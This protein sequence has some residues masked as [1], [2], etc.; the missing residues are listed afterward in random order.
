MLVVVS[1][2]LLILVAGL[3]AVWAYDFFEGE[4]LVHDVLD[5]LALRRRSLAELD[6]VWAANPRRS[7][8]VVSLTTIPSRL[9]SLHWTLASLMRQTV[10]PARIVLN[11]PRFSRREQCAYDV[12]EAL[13]RLAAVEIR[14]VDDLGPA[15]KIVPTLLA[16][17]PDRMIVALDDDRIYP[18]DLIE[19]LER[20]ARADPEAAVTLGGW[21]VPAD[22][23]D[24]P[25]TIASNF[26]M[27]PPAPVRAPR[28]RARKQ[29]DVLLGFCAYLVRPRFFDLAALADWSGAPPEAFYVD[30][31]W[32]SAHCR[33]D[34]W[35][36]P[37]RLSNYQP[38]LLRGFYRA[39][40]LGL[41]NRGAGGHEKR[42]NTIVLR[43]FRQAWRVGGDHLPRA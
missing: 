28:L 12:P 13:R 9:G 14:E 20:A 31:V 43:H 36:V 8:V 40:S 25:T 4:N 3:A 5:E 32:I 23:V 38:K 19:T 34:K 22:Y 7:E 2:S 33:A 17:P 18:A 15:T 16:E 41:I 10:A 21:I 37:S 24:R 35:V 39:T 26:F 6:G 27:R 42:H 1:L 30:D 29:V 11:L